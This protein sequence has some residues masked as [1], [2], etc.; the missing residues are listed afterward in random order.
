MSYDA[1][2]HNDEGDDGKNDVSHCD[3]HDATF[4]GWKSAKIT[5]TQKATTLTYRN[6]YI[7]DNNG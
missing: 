4:W 2:I 6:N 3:Y 1:T 5:K 7:H